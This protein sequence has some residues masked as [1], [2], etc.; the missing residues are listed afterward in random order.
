M[1]YV[2][3]TYIHLRIK[4]TYRWDTATMSIRVT[5]YSVS[6]QFIVGSKASFI[7]HLNLIF[8]FIRP[9]S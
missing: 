6:V 1:D 5:Y 3:V 9:R 2:S 8:R 7:H 4:L